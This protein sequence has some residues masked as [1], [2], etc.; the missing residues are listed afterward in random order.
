MQALQCKE[1]ILLK[2]GKYRISKIIQQL[3]KNVHEN[4]VEIFF[5]NC[6]AVYLLRKVNVVALRGQGRVLEC[7]KSDLKMIMMEGSSS[8]SGEQRGAKEVWTVLPHHMS[9][10]PHGLGSCLAFLEI[11]TIVR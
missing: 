10:G 1:E 9:G 4:N 8:T 5:I 3:S 6:V 11:I 7:G 2:I